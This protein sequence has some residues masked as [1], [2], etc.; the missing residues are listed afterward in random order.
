MT[1]L[2]SRRAMT[3]STMPNSRM[4]RVRDS[5]SSSEIRRGLA[6]SGRRRSRSRPTIKR[7][8]A[9]LGIGG[10]AVVFWPEIVAFDPSRQGTLGLGLTLIGT[11]FASAGMLTSAWNQRQRGLP[12]LQGNAYSMLYGTV[13]IALLTIARGST[14]V[15]DPAPVYVLSLLYLAVFS[16]VVGFW[17]YLTLVGHIGPDRAAYATVLFPIIALALST[18]F[19]DFRWT[20]LDAVGIALVLLGNAVILTKRLPKPSPS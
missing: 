11:C 10:I 13:F 19:E 7:C 2:S 1:T 18:W 16:T 4:L 6:G 3:G 8:R 17:S 20:A 14:V 15:F 9:A 5:N 12:V